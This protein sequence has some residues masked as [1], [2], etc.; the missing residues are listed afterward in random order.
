VAKT[1]KKLPTKWAKSVKSSYSRKSLPDYKVVVAKFFDD[2]VKVASQS[3]EDTQ[4][5]YRDIMMQLFLSLGPERLRT[6]LKQL[7]KTYNLP[8]PI[9]ELP[10]WEKST[11]GPIDV[12][13]WR[14]I[15]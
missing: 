4:N 11:D 13:V 1:N 7:A 14:K 2:V 10:G 3:P 15:T 8:E 12:T 5:V 6:T 9:I